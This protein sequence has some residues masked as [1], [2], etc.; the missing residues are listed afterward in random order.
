MVLNHN[1]LSGLWKLLSSC[2]ERFARMK[3]EP[4]WGFELSKVTRDVWL[5]LWPTEWNEELDWTCCN[6]NQS[7]GSCCWSVKLKA[8]LNIFLKLFQLNIDKV[9]SCSFK[10]FKWKKQSCFPEPQD[11]LDS[12]FPLN[13]GWG[14]EWY[15]ELDGRHKQ[16]SCWVS[17]SQPQTRCWGR[18][19]VHKHIHHTLT[20]IHSYRSFFV[21]F[22]EPSFSQR[23]LWSI[24]GGEKFCSGLLISHGPDGLCEVARN[25]HKIIFHFCA[26]NS[27]HTKLCK[28]PVALRSWNSSWNL[29]SKIV[30]AMLYKYMCVFF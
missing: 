3:V 29:Q 5:S 20:Y 21:C 28:L 25:D 11:D 4:I 1:S 13:S 8:N 10:Y 7:S 19:S 24:K 15:D 26:L 23:R 6:W 22:T 2:L 17:I 14:F 9:L 18:L 30:L 16:E 12:S 27:L